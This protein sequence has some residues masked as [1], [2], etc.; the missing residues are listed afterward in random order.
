MAR[1][2]ID[3][4]GVGRY[5]NTALVEFSVEPFYTLPKGYGKID[6]FWTSAA[7]DW[8]FIRLVRNSYGFPVDADD[9]DTLLET[10]PEN[11]PIYY[12]DTD[13]IQ[14]RTYYYSIFLQETTTFSWVRAGNAYGV[15]VKD[16]TSYDKMYRYLPEIF[17][18]TDIYELSTD[19]EN[20]D[21]QN[22]LKL[23]AFEY[24]LQKTLATNVMYAYDTTFVDGR[25]VPQMMKQFGLKYEPEIGLKQSRILLRNAIKIYKNKGSKDGLT[26]YLKSYTGY[27]TSITLGKNL[28]LDFNCSSFEENIGFW[29]STSATLTRQIDSTALSA[30]TEA[31]APATYPNS[32]DGLLKAVVTAAGTVALTCGL[33]APIT[34]GIPVTTGLAYTFSIYGQA[35]STARTASLTIRWYDRFGTL[36]STSTAGTG[37]SLITGGWNA[38]PTVTDT[39]PALASF[40]IPT[41]SLA[42]TTIGETFYF[43]AAQFEQSGD[44]TDFEEARVLKINF[45]AT[46]INELKNPNFQLNALW[47]STNST[48]ELSD[49]VPGVQ[50]SKALKSLV[51]TPTTT[52]AVTLSSE[53]LTTVTGASTH[54]FSIYAQIYADGGTDLFPDN[55]MYCT[56][57]WY[58]ASGTLLQTDT[59]EARYPSLDVWARPSVTGTAPANT[60][61]G[62]ATLVWTPALPGYN[63]VVD[64]ALFEESAFTNSY[65][66]GNT[67]VA[68][69]S[70]LFWEGT[71]NNSR[72]HYYKNRA[73]IEGRLVEDL[74]NQLTEGTQF[75]MYFAQPDV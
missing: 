63:M 67:G 43:D 14:G 19:K 54:T 34:K 38:R 9:G 70:N 66:D 73:T 61:Y 29:A 27:D 21:L 41:I 69:I 26:T 47:T 5:G 52:A 36:L 53:N 75:Q 49:V 10:G 25:Y 56:I 44:V 7:G 60:S 3:Y 32:T 33:S 46:R 72:S 24:D 8:D 11:S 51:V 57:K 15:S 1:Y 18:S 13:L 2:G 71:P 39:A 64:E 68:S 65:F 16:Y 6:L 37:V 45:I 30:Y 31:T 28:F 59:G 12:A 40:A 48:I 20:T 50:P 35:D 62:V 42:S 58:N 74:P 17:R 55:P 22:F 23:F 4:Y